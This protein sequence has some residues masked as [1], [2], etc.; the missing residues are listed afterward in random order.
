MLNPDIIRERQKR[1]AS[2]LPRLL[3]ASLAGSALVVDTGDASIDS[4]L[5]TAWRE[6]VEPEGLITTS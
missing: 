6:W 4:R 3:R 2:E 1:F 5:R